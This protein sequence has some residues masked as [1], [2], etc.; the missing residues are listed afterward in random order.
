MHLRGPV[1]DAQDEATDEHVSQWKIP[2]RTD[3][4]MN[5]DS[6]PCNARLHVAAKH[7]ASADVQAHLPV[8]VVLVDLIGC[9]QHEELELLQLHPS[10]RKHGLNELLCGQGFAFGPSA[11]HAHEAHVQSLLAVP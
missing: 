4:T 7:L 1:C 10:L 11:V 8:I 3:A 2:G 9:A 6:L 5:L